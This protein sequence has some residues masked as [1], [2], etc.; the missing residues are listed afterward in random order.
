M[1][2]EVEVEEVIIVMMCGIIQ[3]FGIFVWFFQVFCLDIEQVSG[4]IIIIRFDL[5]WVVVNFDVVGVEDGDIIFVEVK[6]IVWVKNFDGIYIEVD[7]WG[8]LGID[9]IFFYYYV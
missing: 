1:C 6:S 7:E 9:E 5:L 4:E 8:E 2:G 3:E